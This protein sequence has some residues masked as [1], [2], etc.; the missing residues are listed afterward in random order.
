MVLAQLVI[1]LEE[2]KIGPI[3][4]NIVKNKLRQIK[5][6]CGGGGGSKNPRH[7]FASEGSTWMAW[8]MGTRKFQ[9]Q[10]LRCLKRLFSHKE[11]EGPMVQGS[12]LSPRSQ[13]PTIVPASLSTVALTLLFP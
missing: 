13:G 9:I 6:K 8:A 5:N 7:E 12:N 10:W 2:Y 4:L 11:S 3:S 1:H